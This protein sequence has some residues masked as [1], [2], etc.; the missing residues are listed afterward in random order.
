[1]GVIA[2]HAIVG[3]G[4]VTG[5]SFSSIV[6]TVQN[7]KG[8]FVPEVELPPPPPKPEKTIEPDQE[9]V[10]PPVHAPIPPIDLGPQRPPVDTTPIIIPLPDPIPYIAPRPTPS[11]TAAARPAFDPV[12]TKPRNNPGSWVTVND[13]RSS[14]INRGMTGTAKFRLEVG[15]NGRVDSCTI[16]VSSGHDELDK[17]TCAL[18]TQRAR[19]DPA[20]D[21]TGAKVSGS[22]GNAVR[23]ELPD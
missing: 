8:I 23:W 2:I 21:E 10:T 3:Y 5:L 18:V 12:G 17:A 16:T 11:A 22:Y 15:A 7:P 14:W 6:E 4:L 1:V 9:F 19:F 20:K 13:Y